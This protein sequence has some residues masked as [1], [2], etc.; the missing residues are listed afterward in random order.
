[1][2][3]KEIKEHW[4]NL[5]KKYGEDLGSTTKTP[6]IK[7]LEINALSDA[8]NSVSNSGSKLEVLEVGCG[9]GHNLFGLH[10]IFNNYNFTGVDY[11]PQMISNA[12]NIKKCEGL[13]RV[14]FFVGDILDL[15]GNTELKKEYDI[16]FTDRC[17]INLNSLA[18]QKRGFEQLS[19]KVK[20][21]GHIVIIENCIQTYGNQNFCRKSIGLKPRTPDEY[22]HFIDENKFIE[23]A[24]NGLKLKLIEINDFGSLHD[25]VLYVLLP[26]INGGKI[27]YSHPIMD[28]VTELSINTGHKFKN[29][30][31]SF[32]QNR[33]YLFKKRGIIIMKNIIFIF[34]FDGVIVDTIQSLYDVYLDFSNEFGFKGNKEE[35]NLLNGPKISEIVSFLREKHNIKQSKEELSNIYHKKLSSIYQNARLNDG[36]EEILK[37][38]KSKNIKIALA[39]SSKKE[40]IESVF[41]RF[42]LNDYFDF[43]I[44]GDDI[45]LAKPSP[46]IYNAVKRKY[47]Q[48]EWYVVEDSVNGLQAAISAGMKTIFYNP[49]NKNIEKDITYEINALNQIKNVITEINL[50]CF[51][52]SK[53]KKITLKVVEHD[54]DID[55]SQKRII[56][57]LWN[58]EL[59]KRKLFNGKILSYKAHKKIGD[60]LNIECFITQYKYFFAQV[61]NPDLNLK[62]AIIGV[63]GI[64]IDKDNN[65]V[66]AAR[67]NATEYEGFYEFIP[68]GNVDASKI[69]N[70]LVLFQEHLIEEFEEET[71][72]KKENI[73]NIEPYCVIFDKNHGVYDVCSKIYINGLLEN[74]M[75]SHQNEE[76]KNIEI[77][78]LENIHK[79]IDKNNCVPTSVVILNNLE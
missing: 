57:N 51:T 33:L 43:I 14:D 12:L 27:D 54:P 2:K 46:E 15:E 55:T 17:L 28:A 36:I 10:S 59:Q 67:H 56:D 50:N 1:M 13:N 31:G 20:N 61:K 68:A 21:G 23:F 64:I 22:N 60:T 16:V 73:K 77:I 72:L 3:L 47:P 53:A 30:F 8:V 71:K 25:I 26:K 69:K 41:N 38:L 74:V 79:K 65:T 32:G 39:S 75:N 70:G 34:D 66:L 5:A 24:Q 63:S 76:Y 78:N 44:T 49:E 29:C 19:R 58:Q 7:R 52:I 11:S 42:K 40:E 18:L 9:N 62:I 35:F 37:L 4:E 48:Y 45:E 6:T